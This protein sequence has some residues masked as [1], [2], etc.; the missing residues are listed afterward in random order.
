[1]AKK[2]AKKSSKKAKTVK[3]STGKG[4]KPIKFKK[5]GLHRALGV[6]E[7]EKIPADKLAAAK[8]RAKPGSKLAKQLAL[9]KGLKKMRG[10]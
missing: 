4:K 7:G 1:M 10:K 8:K 5:G 9:A 3:I 6:P 2:A